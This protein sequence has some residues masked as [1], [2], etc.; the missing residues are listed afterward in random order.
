M[1]E[2][3]FP[4]NSK[5]KFKK[6]VIAMDVAKSISEG[7]AREVVCAKFNNNLIDMTA[8]LTQNGNIQFLKFDDEEGMEVFRHSSAHLLA[9][10]VVDLFPEALP[11]IGPVVEEGFYYDFD[12]PPF[13]EEDL[14]RIEN[15]MNELVK[16]K[17]PVER[18]ELSKDEAL[19]LFKNNKYKLEMIED[20]KNISAYKQ[21]DF[22]DLCRGPHVPNTGMI[23]S[24][25][26]M[27][28]AGA[29]WHG[30]SKNK[31]L[32][33]IYGISFPD[34]KQLNN[35][36]KLLEEAKN[37]DHRK[38]GRELDLYSFH[39]EAPGMPFF[40]NKGTFL[41]N[42]LVN[43]T[44]ELLEKRNYELVRTPIIM[45]KNLWMQSG[46]WDHYKENMYYTKIDEQD[47]AVK[48]MNCPGHILV[49]KTKA[50]SYRDFPLKQG[51]FG[52]VHRHELSGALSGL[53][54]VRCFTQDDAH[55]FCTDD[56]IEEQL[57]EL[58]EFVDELYSA[59]GFD[60]HLE[61]STKPDKAMGDPE[62]WDL[63]EQKLRVVLDRTGKDYQVN[64]GDGAFYGPKIDVHL[65]D[66][67]GRTWQCGT[68]QVDFQ[69]PEKFD[70]T[71][72]GSDGKKHRPIMLHRA[73][74]GSVERFLG[75]L[76]EHFAGKFPM[77]LSP[78]QVRVLTVADR[79]AD[80]AKELLTKLKSAGLRATLDD[81]AESISKKVR[82][83]QLDQI[84]YILVFGEKEQS[85][86]LQI[87][88]R[89][90][91]VSGPVPVDEFIK[92]CVEEVRLKK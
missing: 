46:H 28:L 51:E 24:F 38:I 92:N 84:N 80:S 90:N 59:F 32:Q 2:I 76:V 34:N 18:M 40:H 78:E 48:P 86:D 89:D 58:I 29:Y 62:L 39:E 16:L 9:H 30:D 61:L 53:F 12:H 66:A 13:N 19:K 47:F 70:L 79:F 27:K 20:M 21:G 10:A 56:Q 11:T 88:T 83:A 6:G 60:Y 82:N 41:W 77:W 35:Y 52:L 4:D 75:I 8:E 71:Y 50:H 57:I 55:V 31:Q 25:K 65:K 44:T 68:I 26:L 91:E 17:L 42:S 15:R 14:L 1:I 64:E 33:R 74:L 37:R 54:R 36:L 49:Y 43:F 81:S 3:K 63:A 5:K 23:K 72:E 69:M 85:G 45:N 7:L 22:I 87:R 73:I 67:I